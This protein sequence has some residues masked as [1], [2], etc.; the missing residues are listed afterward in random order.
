M[1]YKDYYKILGV[2]R[3]AGDDEIK[4][5]YRKLAKEHHPDRNPGNDQAEEKFKEIN[6]AYQVLSDAEKRQHYDRLGRSYSRYQQTGGSPGDFNWEDWFTYGAG[7]QTGGNVRVEVG[8]IEDIFGG[9]FAERFSTGGFS[10]FFT[11]I[12]GGMGGM[13]S[14]GARDRAQQ[15]VTRPSYQHNIDI[16]LYEAYHGTTRRIELDGRRIDVTIPP[17][18]RTGTK[19]RVKDVLSSQQGGPIGDLY[20][21]VQVAEDAT[22]ERKGNN[23]YTDVDI[24]LFTAVLGGE[25]TVRTLRGDV[26]LTIPP[27]TQPDHSFR[28]KG[29]G[30]PHLK[31]PERFGD[32]YVRIKVELP[33]KLTAQQKELFEQLAEIE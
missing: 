23:L 8:N 26:V 10:D 18:A 17:G 15:R 20:L 5:A 6:E 21:V 2:D 9:E 27:G 30:M 13:R 4:R 29:R 16:S 25:V 22:Y 28:L 3:N 14:A 24:D 19:V 33:R 1:E 7:P 12:F 11:S 32:L 31:D